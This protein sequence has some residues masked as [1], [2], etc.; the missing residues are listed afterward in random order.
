M[1]KVYWL[2]KAAVGYFVQECDATDAAQRTNDGPIKK[3]L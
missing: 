1:E 2:K 3:L